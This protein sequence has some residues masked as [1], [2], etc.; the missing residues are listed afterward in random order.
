MPAKKEEFIAAINKSYQTDLL[1]IHLGS[2]VLDGEI[3]TDAKV[4]LALRM[5]NRHGLVAGA[6][7][8]GKTRTLQVLAE[9]LSDAGV[10]VFLTD[11]KG[12]L[13]GL[14]NPGVTDARLQ[15]RAKALG[16]E[17]TPTGFPL[18]LYSLSGKKGSQM[19]ATVIEFGPILLSKILDLNDTQAG[20]L[21]VL[22]K[23][24]DDKGLPMVDLNDLKK[25][26]T[27]LSEGQGA[28]E[29]KDSYGKIST[30][31]SGTILRKIVALE[32]QGV[33]NIFGETS[34]DIDDLFQK[35]D[36]KG[37][38]SLLNLSDMQGQ[39]VVFSTFLLSLL[40]ELY[41]KLPEAGDL[42]KPKL[43]F[44]LDEAH[45][46]FNGAPK[47]FL[48]QIEQIIRLI[49]SKGVGV[50]FC[51]QMPQDIPST[52]LSQLGN[53]V[54][55][56][57]RA[58]TPQDAEGLK[59]TVKTYPK[60]NFY[61]IDRALTSMGIGQALIT[62]LNEK[63]I[64][65]E[66]AVTHLCPPRAVMGPMPE[67][68]Y[69]ELLSQSDVFKKYKQ[70][71]DPQSAYEI[72]NA[73]LQRAAEEKAEAEQAKAEEKAAQSSSGARREKST[74]EEVMSSPVAKE[75]GKQLVRGLFGMLFGSAPKASR[76]RRY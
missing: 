3:V 13:S 8:S 35:V 10:P 54:Q 47:A 71:I 18:E 56:V 53:R 59:Q 22:F 64:P 27:Y 49:R 31:T 62:V 5:M 11:V 15:E 48:E 36:G 17:F 32:Q 33:A 58:F 37:L 52:V 69:Q 20:V 28:E 41:T 40:A 38:I 67:N 23:Y 74:L 72:L 29:I 16:I 4:N 60:S 1:H 25:V 65:T 61:E 45:L 2:A 73:K 46:L 26:L 66:V 19:R 21:A 57:L 14:G 7:G 43:V 39:P 12:D 51:T 76:G 44:F 24:A 42:D 63:G 68:Q 50:F 6:T 75:V 30:S 70:A 34:F 9:Q 55:H